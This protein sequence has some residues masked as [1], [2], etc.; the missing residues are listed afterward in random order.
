MNHPIMTKSSGSNT[1]SNWVT[2]NNLQE[3]RKKNEGTR[4]KSNN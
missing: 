1:N 3:H 4:N 2:G